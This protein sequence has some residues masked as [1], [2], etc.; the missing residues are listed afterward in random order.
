MEVRGDRQWN[1]RGKA[2]IGASG[3]FRLCV[4]VKGVAAPSIPI[5][6]LPTSRRD[7]KVATVVSVRAVPETTW[8]SGR[9]NGKT[10]FNENFMLCLFH[11]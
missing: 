1:S 6:K 11:L 4:N 8:I 10:L 3:T 7:D 5:E 9:R 2:Y